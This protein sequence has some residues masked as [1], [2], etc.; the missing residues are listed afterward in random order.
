MILERYIVDYSAAVLADRKVGNLFLFP[1]TENF[2]EEFTHC[3]KKLCP[4]GVAMTQFKVKS[5]RLIYVYRPD[6]LAEVL[7]KPDCRRCLRARGY[8]LSSLEAVIDG[9]RDR[10][11]QADFPHEIGFLLGYPIP[12]VLTFLSDLGKNPVLTGYWQVYHDADEA[13]QTFLELNQCYT[14]YKQRYDQGVPLEELVKGNR[15]EENCCHLLE[16]HRQYG[17]DGSSS[18]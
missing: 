15:N 18:C 10:I 7:S 14:Q 8:Q 2:H 3:E 12:D 17:A 16:R 9:F 5:G 13:K 4:F 1:S 11:T 6:R